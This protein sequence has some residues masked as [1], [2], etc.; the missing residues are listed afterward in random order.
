MALSMMEKAALKT[1]HAAWP[2]AIASEF[3]QEAR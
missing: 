1:E 3:E 2:D